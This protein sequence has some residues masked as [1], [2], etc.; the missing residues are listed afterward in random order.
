MGF[1]QITDRLSTERANMKEIIRDEFSSQISDMEREILHL[2]E[3]MTE[4]KANHQMELTLKEK[5]LEMAKAEKE[6]ELHEVY[7]R[8]G[9]PR[10]K[11][12]YRFE[13]WLNKQLCDT[14]FS[15]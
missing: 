7:D 11:S 14:F 13:T 5:E 15:G 4:M 12:M 8:Y 6:K 10:N 3:A 9:P 2:R 1:L